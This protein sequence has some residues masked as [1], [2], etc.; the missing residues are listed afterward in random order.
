[1]LDGPLQEPR[2]DPREGVIAVQRNRDDVSDDDV[3][4]VPRDRHDHMSS[5]LAEIEERL[6]ELEDELA[7]VAPIVYERQRL[8]LARA[9]LLGEPPPSAIASGRRVTRAD[10][11]S[12]LRS[13]PGIRAGEIARILDAGQPAISAHLY[14][15]KGRCFHCRGGRWFLID[16]ERSLLGR[17]NAPLLPRLPLAPRSFATGSMQSGA[18]ATPRATTTPRPPAS[19]RPR[20]PTASSRPRGPRGAR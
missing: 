9:Q 14:R 4:T 17:E 2:P 16:E 19:P 7:K 13:Q 11:A 20:H 12:V 15:G 6:E 8:L 18:P 10:V 3:T 1:M 5:L